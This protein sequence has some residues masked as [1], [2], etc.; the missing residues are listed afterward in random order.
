MSVA[1]VALCTGPGGLGTVD[2]A[3]EDNEKAASA[4]PAML[5]PP[6]T[7]AYSSISTNNNSNYGSGSSYDYAPSTAMYAKAG[8]A[9]P[10]NAG[11]GYTSSG[12][13]YGYAD[14]IGANNNE[15]NWGNQFAQT[16]QSAGGHG[17]MPTSYGGRPLSSSSSASSSRS[18]G[19]QPPLTSSKRDQNWERK[20]R[21]WLARKNGASRPQT[22]TPPQSLPMPPGSAYGMSG[23]G[24]AAPMPMMHTSSSSNPWDDLANANAPPSPLSKFVHQQSQKHS[25]GAAVDYERIGTAQSYGAPPP[26]TAAP[27]SSNTFSSGN[28][29]GY[30]AYAGAPPSRS[31]FAGYGAPPPTSSNSSSTASVSHLRQ[32]PSDPR[33][34]YGHSSLD[35]APMSRG[36]SIST[37]AGVSTSGGYGPGTMNTTSATARQP[38]G[39]RSNWS[40]FS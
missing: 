14:N 7:G 3:G 34:Q 8:G 24:M 31:G 23:A 38:P 19:S 35:G 18:W 6:R 28:S 36:G 11:L 33:I 16:P 21:Q 37:P 32:A 10:N 25:F 39:G 27:Y 15:S 13:S 9:T 5:P 20:R 22:M 40:P 29:S 4:D 12:S 17:A 30:G 2:A 1:V 26:L